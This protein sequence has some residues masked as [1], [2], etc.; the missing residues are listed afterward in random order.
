MSA[1]KHTPGPWVTGKNNCGGGSN[2]VD[3]LGRHLA[4]TAAVRNINGQ[5]LPEKDRVEDPEAKANARLIAAA[6]EMLETLRV[7]LGNLSSLKASC[8]CT[9]YDVW[10]DVVESVI[11]KAEGRS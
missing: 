7:T 5:V 4:H 11:A 1:P 10:I 2:V 9:T 3:G 6:P 8:N